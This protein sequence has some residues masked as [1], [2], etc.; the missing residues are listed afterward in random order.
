M[1]L[2]IAI[3]KSGRL[4][5]DSIKLLKECGIDINNG[6][7]KLKTEASNFPL[8]VFFL[9]DDD[10]PQYV[11]DGVADIG[12]VGENVIIEKARPVKIAEKLGFGKCRLSLAIPKAAEY[13]GVK[14]MDKLRIATSYPVILQNFLNQHNITAD[15]HE[16]SGS[17]EIAPGIGLA[18]AI[19]DLVSSGSTLFM[20]GL[21]EVEVIL[22]SEAALISNDNLTPEQ[23]ALLQKLLFRIQSV[24]KAKNNKYVLLNAP[25]DKLQEIISLLPG[26]KSPTVLPLAEEG[27]S[28]VHSVLNENAFWDIIENLKAAGAQGILVVP[29]EKMII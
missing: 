10:I 1:K 18:D 23:E 25:N 5:D 26:M 6:V 19:C 2:R 24:K 3:Q 4:H 16:I 27:W 21:K 28:S 12:I 22:K 29:I 7:N 17:V 9:R 14:D 13:N 11:E 15:I 8:E 20:N